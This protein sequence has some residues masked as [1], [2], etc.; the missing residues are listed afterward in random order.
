MKIINNISI[1]ALALLTLSFV[2]CSTTETAKEEVV[3]NVASGETVTVEYAV[4]GMVCSMGCAATIQDEVLGM[5]GVSACDVSFENE[6]AHVEFD[7]GLTSE[8]DII[9][10]IESV[11]DGQYK[12]AGE[13]KEKVVEENNEEEVEGNDDNKTEEMVEVSLP[14]FEIPN[15]FAFLLG[16]L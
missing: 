1:V 8:E 6:K 9:A 4:E 5:E 13:W 16:R 12:V 7:N 14:S 2:S 10:K 11:A 15:L 3:E